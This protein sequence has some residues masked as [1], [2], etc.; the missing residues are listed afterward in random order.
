MHA[1]IVEMNFFDDVA[2]IAARRLRGAGYSVSSLESSEDVLHKYF[3]ARKRRI[4]KMPR[5][6]YIAQDFQCPPKYKPAFDEICRKA[7]AGEHLV[8]H[9]SRKVLKLD[10]NDALLNDW[11]IHHLHLS[12]RPD[13][14][15][16]GLV[17]GTDE[18]LFAR[19][20]ADGMYCLTIM[21]HGTWA[22]RE[23]VEI[24][25]DNW[26]HTLNPIKGI[27]GESKKDI[28][29]KEIMNLRNAG[30]NAAIAMD[31]GTVYAM[32][33]G[34]Y[35]TTGLNAQVVLVTDGLRDRCRFLEDQTRLLVN[36]HMEA[37]R[38]KGITPPNAYAVSLS[39]DNGTWFARDIKNKLDAPLLA[40]L[41]P[42]L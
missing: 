10:Y 26:K 7:K 1:P 22:Y 21:G 31:D 9:Q 38:G 16:K 18:V 40:P 19:F 14:K 25:H 5:T 23:L 27:R 33:G 36:L 11:D 3:N 4:Y 8:P 12:T 24:L 13:P 42:L 28:G 35:A 20:T 30:V 6:V 17:K 41:I 32:L 37:E 39:D 34:G 29:S 2:R 15:H